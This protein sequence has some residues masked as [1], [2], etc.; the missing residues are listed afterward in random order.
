MNEGKIIFI[1]LDGLGDLAYDF[2]DNKTPLEY[3]N[4]PNLD[5]LAKK[6]SCGMLDV[7]RPGLPPGSDSAHLSLFGYDYL[8]EYPGRGPFE[9]IGYGYKLQEG[10]IA[11]RTNF[12]SVRRSGNQLIIVDRRAGRISGE[13]AK[14][15]GESITNEITEIDGVSIQ[16]THTIE[17]RGFLVLSG[18]GLSHEVTDT[19]PHESGAPVLKSV[20]WANAK[21]HNAALKTAT[22]V[23]KFVKATYELLEKHPINKQLVSERKLPANIILPRGAGIK[24]KLEPFEIRWGLKPAAIAAGPLYRGVALELGFELIEVPNITGL[25]NTNLDGKFEYAARNIDKYDFIFVHVKATDYYSHKKDAKGKA[26]FIEK[27][28]KAL[29]PIIESYEQGVTILVTGDHTTPCKYGN[30]SGHPVPILIAGPNTRQDSVELFGERY[31]TN[32]A[33]H[34]LRGHHLMP[35]LL[36]YTGRVLEYG[37]RSSP[38]E[39]IFIPKKEWTP[40]EL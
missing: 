9:A 25:P 31:C 13:L 39:R 36:T 22:V 14:E 27:I 17:H 16:Y 7:L 40:L 34:R 12:A 32:G 4:T 10:N 21:N 30:H 6:G 35:L 37:L 5:Y 29:E 24:T 19:D 26:S 11:F 1:V 38:Y 33:L 15:L 20:P 18:D 8:T 23:N 3:A 2:F 28:D